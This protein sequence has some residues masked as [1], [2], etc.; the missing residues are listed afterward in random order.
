MPYPIPTGNFHY[1]K[2]RHFPISV[3]RKLPLIILDLRQTLSGTR[4]S[5]QC[6]I[7]DAKTCVAQ[8]ERTTSGLNFH[9]LK[10][11]PEETAKNGFE[12]LGFRYD[13]RRV[14]VRDSTISR[15]YGK[16][17]GAAKRD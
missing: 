9:H 6:P 15:F 3:A 5:R 10:Q 16:V 11:H 8:F 1:N 4:I 17:A 13:G 2:L 7:K 12:Y 14:Y